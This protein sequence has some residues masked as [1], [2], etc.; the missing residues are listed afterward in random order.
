MFNGDSCNVTDLPG[1]FPGC[2]P[3]KSFVQYP[4]LGLLYFTLTKSF[5][6]ILYNC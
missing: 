3:G 2:L 4:R 6:L 5:C 1:P